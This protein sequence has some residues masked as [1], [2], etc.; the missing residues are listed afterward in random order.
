MLRDG[1]LSR[2]LGDALACLATPFA[3]LVWLTS[4]RDH[5]SGRYLH[6]GWAN[7]SSPAEVHELLRSTHLRVFE[8]VARLSLIAFCRELRIH[9]R[10]IGEDEP[11]AVRLWLELEPYSEMVPEG[12]PA[13]LRGLFVFQFRSALQVLAQVPDWACL[14]VPV[15]P[16]HPPPGPQSPLHTLN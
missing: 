10:A 13:L 14:Q 4:L 2:Y 7:Y 3:Q 6:E 15:A 12:C 8:A 11:R 5:Y 9:F 16:P 1:S